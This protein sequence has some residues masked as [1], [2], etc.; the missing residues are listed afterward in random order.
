MREGGASK[1][2]AATPS[3]AGVGKE[4]ELVFGGR[5]G[6][7]GEGPRFW[8]PPRTSPRRTQ[9]GGG[10][11]P[12]ALGEA[13]GHCRLSFSRKCHVGELTVVHCLE[14]QS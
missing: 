10:F 8:Y 3:L 11:G 5:E 14:L 12:V 6:V 1:G 7:F 13:R 2:A 9:C 4:G